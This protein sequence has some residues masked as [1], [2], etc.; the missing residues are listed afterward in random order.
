MVT[1]E[2]VDALKAYEADRSEANKKQLLAADAAALAANAKFKSNEADKAIMIDGQTDMTTALIEELS[3]YAARLINSVRQMFGMKD[4]TVSLGSIKFTDEI[5]KAYEADNWSGFNGHYND[6][7]NQA[8]R[9]NGLLEHPGG[10][11][12]ENLYS[13]SSSSMKPDGSWN[14]SKNDLKSLIYNAMLGFLYGDSGSNWGHA[15]SITGLMYGSSTD[16]CYFGVS[17]SK[18]SRPSFSTHFEFVPHSY[19]IKDAS[20]F[21]TKSIDIPEIDDAK[22]QEKI[23]K[24]TQELT[25]RKE[26]AKIAGEGL[27]SARKKADEANQKLEA[28]KAGLEKATTDNQ[29]AKK[30]LA[31][32][33]KAVETA[34]EKVN[35]AQGVVDKFNSDA[36]TKQKALDAAQE[37]LEAAKQEKALKVTI[38]EEAKK[39]LCTVNDKLSAAQAALTAAKEKLA[40]DKKALESGERLVEQKKA[41]VASLKQASEALSAALSDLKKAESAYASAVKKLESAKKTAETDAAT[42]HS[43]QAKADAAKVKLEETKEKLNKLKNHLALNEEL[44][45]VKGKSADATSGAAFIGNASKQGVMGQSNASTLKSLKIQVSEK[46]KSQLTPTTTKLSSVFPQTGFSDDPALALLGVTLMGL[47]ITLGLAELDKRNRLFLK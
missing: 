22:A 1:Q 25:N 20:K 17:F 37:A 40:D 42:Y 32:A 29:E 13:Y 44:D 11:L 47:L 12:Y 10:N 41:E 2:Y 7:I 33:T 45:S 26:D 5:A 35:V 8:A 30:Q 38:L 3:I 28:A 36:E 24:L 18:A 16:E 27:E 34:T 19:Y 6:A 23:N 9:N 46:K 39:Q 15:F 14:L 4:V 21:D 43:L 31:A